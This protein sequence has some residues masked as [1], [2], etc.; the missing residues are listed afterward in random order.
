MIKVSCSG[1]DELKQQLARLDGDDAYTIVANAFRRAAET[2][3]ADAKARTPVRT[4]F[5][6]AN[7]A[8]KV[9]RS[10]KSIARATISIGGANWY[11]TDAFYGSFVALGHLSGKR[12]SKNRHKI[13]GR[14]FLRD[15]FRA[16]KIDTA[17]QIVEDIAKGLENLAAA[18]VNLD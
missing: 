4:G 9:G 13:K 6:K 11:L 14:N 17:Q 1:L 10:K 5:L 2:I 7:I 16:H 15:A 12:G 8:V 18:E 3:A